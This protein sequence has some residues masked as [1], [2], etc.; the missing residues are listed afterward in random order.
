MQETMYTRVMAG[1]R[2]GMHTMCFSAITAKAL[3]IVVRNVRVPKS[4][5]SVVKNIDYEIVNPR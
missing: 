1:V 5:L 4:V 2:S 3:V